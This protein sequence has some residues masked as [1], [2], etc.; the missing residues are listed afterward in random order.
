[1]RRKVEILKYSSNRMGTQTNNPTKAQ[2]FA[3]AIRGSYQ[4]RTYSQSNIKNGI[5]AA[6][7]TVYTSTTA[8]DVPGPP[9]MLYEDT[10]VPLYNLINDANTT[11]FGIINQDLISN[12]NIWNFSGLTDVV[13]PYISG[14]TN[15][16]TIAT[17]YIVNVPYSTYTFYLQTPVAILISGT[18]QTGGAIPPANIPCSLQVS[19]DKSLLNVKY[20]FSNVAT[21]ASL[22]FVDNPVIKVVINP[23]A[24]TFSAICYLGIMQ[25]NNMVLSTQAGFIYDIQSAVSFN[26]NYPGNSK[27]TQYF[28]TPDITTY[29]DTSLST[30]YPGN[31]KGCIVS[32]ASTVDPTKFPKVVVG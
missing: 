27:Y 30:V 5:I 21:T 15:Y 32:G 17:I 2:K 22:A 9:V 31:S 10:T 13:V 23:G 11:A 6:C 12:S 1:M 24:S 20:S 26:I 14:K 8:C 25:I 3:Q 16:S 4:R 18:L 29:F 7:P 19:I 28:N